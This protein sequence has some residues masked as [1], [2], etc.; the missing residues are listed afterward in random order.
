[1]TDEEEVEKSFWLSR[2]D[3]WVVNRKM[4]KIVLLKFKRTS[5]QSVSYYQDLWRVAEKQHTF[6]LMGLRALATDRDWEV[7]VVRLVVGQRSVQEKEWLET[8]KIFGIGKE[9]GKNINHRLGYNCSTSMSNFLE[10]TGGTHLGPPV[11]CRTCQ[12]LGE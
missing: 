9:D 10:A 8:F 3:G 11:V 2:P 6:I 1:M 7:E 12:G 5:E 4:K